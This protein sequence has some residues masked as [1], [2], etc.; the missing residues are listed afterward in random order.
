MIYCRLS[1][2][3]LYEGISTNLK[4]AFDYILSTDLN[5]LP[6]GKTEIK[7]SDIYINKNCIELVNDIDSF[8]VH[9][10]YIDIHIVLKTDDSPNKELSILA[11]ENLIEHQAYKELEDYK[12]L[13]FNSLGKSSELIEI[14][15]TPGFCVIF[16]SGEVH[17]PGIFNKKSYKGDVIA[18]KKLVKCVVKV[19]DDTKNLVGV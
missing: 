8:E 19:L 1:D 14:S 16:L 11:N 9:K 15:L 7:G 12:L 10:R 4:T 17:K 5:S 13:K 6:F 2:L 18:S 3:K